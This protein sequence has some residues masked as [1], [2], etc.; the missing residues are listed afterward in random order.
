[1][2]STRVEW[3][4]YDAGLIIGALLRGDPRH[5]EARPLVEAARRGD[6][7]ACVT[8]G[9]LS[10]VY[11]ALTWAQAQ[12]PHAP[13]DAAEAIRSI[14]EAPSA[15]RV[16][17]ETRGVVLRAL[18]LAAAHGLSARRIHDARHAATA[19]HAGVTRV[20]TYD[21]GDWRAFVSDGIQVTGP[22]SVLAALGMQP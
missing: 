4:L 2:R 15:I 19:L 17:H 6:V 21:V 18:D 16:L 11:A 3:V 10:E 14:V 13:A 20:Y 7:R 12:P 1:M 22:P 9:I 5:A 8:P